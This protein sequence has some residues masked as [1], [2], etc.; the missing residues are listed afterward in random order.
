[1]IELAVPITRGDV[2]SYPLDYRSEC[3]E[4]LSRLPRGI[5]EIIAQAVMPVGPVSVGIMNGYVG[6]FAIP[7]TPELFAR[8]RGVDRLYHNRRVGPIERQYPALMSAT[9][10]GIVRNWLLSLDEYTPKL[11]Q[12]FAEWYIRKARELD[13]WEGDADDLRIAEMI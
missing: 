9:C 5:V 2:Y 4:L 11:R 1:M 7:V 3:K 8:I 10:P 12:A 13:E 6:V